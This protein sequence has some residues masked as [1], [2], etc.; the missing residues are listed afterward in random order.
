MYL[1][2]DDISVAN[3]RDWGEGEEESIRQVP[4]HLPLA[5]VPYTLLEHGGTGDPGH[6]PLTGVPYTYRTW[7]NWWEKGKSRRC[8]KLCHGDF[9][10]VSYFLSKEPK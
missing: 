3:E 9:R 8:F 1:H 10:V 2:R 6:L 5:R 7:R 4:G